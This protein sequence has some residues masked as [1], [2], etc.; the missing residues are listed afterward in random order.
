MMSNFNILKSFHIIGKVDVPS[1]LSRLS[2]A[3]S[4]SMS[5]ESRLEMESLEAG[6]QRMFASG[7]TVPVVMRLQVTSDQV[8]GAGEQGVES[9]GAGG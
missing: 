6:R 4:H 8:T 1:F 5:P 9:R 7:V 3:H 2:S